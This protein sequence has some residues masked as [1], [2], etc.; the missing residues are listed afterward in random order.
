[1]ETF[2]ALPVLC[3]GNSPVTGE[4]PSQRPVARSFDV[5]F[6]LR[7]N[8][9]WTKQSRRRSFE[10]SLGS[11]W[12]H[13]NGKC[14]LQKSNILTGRNMLKI[15]DDLHPVNSG[16]W[17][18]R[19]QNKWQIWAPVHYH[20]KGCV[21]IT[22]CKWPKPQNW[23]WKYL[24]HLPLNKVA[25]AFAEDIFERIFLNENTRISTIIS[26]R[27]VPRGSND[28]K[29]ALVQVMAWRRTGDKRLPEQMLIQF[30]D[31]FMRH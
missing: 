8:K 15:T 16:R 20:W 31:A 25:D 3:A 4:F 26:L 9:Q 14:F 29:S 21:F 7:L 24:T 11:V 22:S 1:M 28:K 5:F 13:C 18:F 23:M 27:F 19:E 2:S 6:D 30:T 17:T 12:R 10:T